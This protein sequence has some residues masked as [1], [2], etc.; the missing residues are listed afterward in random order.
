MFGSGF[1]GAGFFGSGFC[2]SGFCGSCCEGGFCSCWAC[3]FGDA[4]KV[5]VPTNDTAMI[6]ATAMNLRLPVLM[7]PL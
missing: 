1:C 5:M 6:M 4:A 3:G 2:G 7:E